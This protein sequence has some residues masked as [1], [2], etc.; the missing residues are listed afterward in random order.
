MYFIDLPPFLPRLTFLYA[1]LYL[2]VERRSLKST[3]ARK[4]F[5]I[6]FKILAYRLYLPET[7]SFVACLYS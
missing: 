1:S 2:L 7:C 6:G 4:F 3:T 5:A